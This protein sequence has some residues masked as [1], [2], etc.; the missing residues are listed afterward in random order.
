MVVVIVV[1]V[2]IVVV[3]VDLVVNCHE[4]HDS[5]QLGGIGRLAG[6]KDCSG[7]RFGGGSRY[8]GHWHDGGCRH[9]MVI[10]VDVV[11]GHHYS[12]FSLIGCHCSCSD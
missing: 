7:R 6:G 2:D 9:R 1:V 8:D 5:S 4:D 10:I 11:N 12:G 3:V